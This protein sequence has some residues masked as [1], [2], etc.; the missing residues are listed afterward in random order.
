MAGSILLRRLLIL[1]FTLQA[2]GWIAR[3]IPAENWL[4]D[5]GVSWSRIPFVATDPTLP[6]HPLAGVRTVTTL[7]SSALVAIGIAFLF[8]KRERA[9]RFF[10]ASVLVHLFLTQVFVFYRA[11]W[12]GLLEL[13]QHL[14]VLGALRLALA[15]ERTLGESQET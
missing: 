2:A 4:P 7:A 8:R 3:L 5:L 10:E 1:F 11:E 14:V 12:L 15:G 13:L 6:D 9:F